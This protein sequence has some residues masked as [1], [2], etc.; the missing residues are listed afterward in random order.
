M[1][2]D[3]FSVG[4]SHDKGQTFQR[5]MKLSDLQGTLTCPAVQTKCAAHWARIQSVFATDGGT[6]TPDGGGT[7][8]QPGSGGSNCSTTGAGSLAALA[9]I[10]AALRKRPHRA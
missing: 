4:V 7:G 8:Q 3:G 5:V 1:F 9:L 10:A 2:Q 6:T